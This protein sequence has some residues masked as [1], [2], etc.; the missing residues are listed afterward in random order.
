MDIEIQT[1]RW[2]EDAR[3]VVCE[4]IGPAELPSQSN[5]H[6]VLT[7][8]GG[9][10]GNHYHEHG[11]EIMTVIGP[12]LVR[13]RDDQGVRDYPVEDRSALRFTIPPGAGHAVLNTG[14][15]TGVIL[16]FSTWPHDP[17]RPDV[18]RDLLLDPVTPT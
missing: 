6:L 11:T 16:S 18:V 8:P 2:V 4:P 17:A 1:P 5:A 13:V 9:V 7:R 10:R 15:G 12:A 14:P 3:G